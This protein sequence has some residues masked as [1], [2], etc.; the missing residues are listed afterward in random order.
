MF[1][2]A[3]SLAV[4]E[5]GMYFG[6]GEV[7]RAAGSAHKLV[8]PYQAVGASDR[9]FIVGATTPPNWTA[10]CRVLG[11][12]ALESDPRFAEANARRRHRPEL[13]AAIEQATR[14][15]PATHWLALP[16]DAALPS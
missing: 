10:F 13:V 9:H 4:W 1:E 6:S 11:L 16:R 8:A 15:K 12:G 3:V 7:A 14:G 2:S 5:A